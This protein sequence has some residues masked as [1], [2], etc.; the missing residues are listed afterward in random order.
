MTWK[1]LAEPTPRDIPRSYQAFQWPDGKVT[2]LTPPREP[3]QSFCDVV[4]G[5][6]SQRA[7]GA[8]DSSDLSTLLWLSGRVIDQQASAFGRDLT[9]RPAPSAG[10]L[11]PIHLLVCTMQNQYWQ[12]YDPFGHALVD[13]RE[14]VIAVESAMRAVEP[15]LPVDGGTLIWLVAELGLTAAKYENSESL[16]WRDAGVL[17]SQ[18]GLVSSLLGLHFCSLGLT[19]SDW[20]NPLDQHHLIRGVGLAIA[21]SPPGDAG[22]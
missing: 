4:N 1:L 20:A 19:G 14:G 16:V 10:A 7:F 5:R 3:R 6:R 15:A 18:L 2:P 9:L 22:K 11:H 17:L 12:R 8:M 21:G 13:V